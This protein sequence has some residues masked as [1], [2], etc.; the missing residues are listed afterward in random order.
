MKKQ[1]TN[2]LALLLI[3]WSSFLQLHASDCCNDNVIITFN[4][5]I[6]ESSEGVLDLTYTLS[7]KE[8]ENIIIDSVTYYIGNNEAKNINKPNVARI[9]KI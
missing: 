9:S 5:E 1:Y 8:N 6:K 2:Y 4:T 7:K 3:I